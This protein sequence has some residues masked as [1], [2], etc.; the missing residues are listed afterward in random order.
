MSDD[1]K[2]RLS[3][4]IARRDAVAKETQ[5]LQGRLE[6]AREE[7]ARIEEECRSK[8]LE[9]DNLDDSITK[10]QKRY[11]TAVEE[12]ENKVSQAEKDLAPFL[13]EDG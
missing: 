7:V 9:P 8:G 4:A 11:D 12:L 10:L 5:R 3:Q 6:A 1:R 2:K 13:R